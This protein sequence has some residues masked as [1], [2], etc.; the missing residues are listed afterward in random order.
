M[1]RFVTAMGRVAAIAATL[2]LVAA[3]VSAQQTGTVTGSVTDASTSAGIQSV[4]VYLVDSGLGT[5][6]NANGR[7][8]ILNV[9]AACALAEAIP[10][11]PNWLTYRG[12]AGAGKGKQIVLIAADQ[13]YR[14]EQS[15]PMLAKILATHHGFDC[16]VLFCVND[17]GL[18]DP[19]MP[20]Y[21]KKGKEKE[22]SNNLGHLYRTLDNKLASGRS[23]ITC[24]VCDTRPLP[25]NPFPLLQGFDFA[26]PSF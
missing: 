10:E 16:T 9:P 11:G 13:E 3:P 23:M 12:K 26:V 5:L 19:T 2:A 22:D 25:P 21:P 7:F 18:V 4:Q 8:L 24:A 15:M 17:E 14:S 20:V 6:S 1:N